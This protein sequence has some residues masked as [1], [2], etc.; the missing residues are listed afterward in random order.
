MVKLLKANTPVL[1]SSVKIV[2]TPTPAPRSIRRFKSIHPVKIIPST[3][4]MD[5]FEQQEMA[6]SRPQVK[7]KLNEWKDWLVNHVPK[8]IKA[9][10]DKT[11]T[12]FKNKLMGLYKKVR[13][14]NLKQK[15]KAKLWIL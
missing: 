12:N 15:K 5:L 13:G 4:D 14:E 7:N 2:P 9:K 8:T 10:V 6:N 3:Q 1:M 11:F